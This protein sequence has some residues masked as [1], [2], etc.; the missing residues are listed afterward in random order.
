MR[1]PALAIL[2]STAALAAPRA[3]L[4]S[5]RAGGDAATASVEVRGDRPL[6]FTTLKLLAPPR[7]VVDC[8]DTAV[9]EVPAEVEV[10]DGTVRRIGVAGAGKRTARVVIELVADAE[11]DVRANGSSIEVRVPRAAPLVAAEG[12]KASRP[13]EVAVEA[14][15]PAAALPAPPPPRAAVEPPAPPVAV[16]VG[17]DPA[18]AAEGRSE[19]PGV[20]VAQAEAA[21]PREPSVAGRVYD[22]KV[23]NI[24]PRNVTTC[25]FRSFRVFNQ[26]LPL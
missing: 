11:F 7:V 12:P 2:L 23:R 5:V 18:H 21:P 14:P 15:P 3:R 1:L 19:A 10:E 25:S 16:V 22:R 13:V 26:R 24:A 17:P 6:S 8:A 9:G 4:L 20:L